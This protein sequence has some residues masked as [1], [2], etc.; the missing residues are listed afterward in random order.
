MFPQGGALVDAFERAVPSGKPPEALV[1]EKSK[2]ESKLAKTTAGQ[3]EALRHDPVPALK[4]ALALREQYPGGGS[5]PG[6]P[7][8]QPV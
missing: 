8:H 3:A 7:P 2:L 5:A 1:A 4:E 6:S